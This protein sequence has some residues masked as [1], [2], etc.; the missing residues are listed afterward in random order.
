LS[1][2]GIDNE[3]T[4][5]RLIAA[6]VVIVFVFGFFGVE[7]GLEFDHLLPD[8]PTLSLTIALGIFFGVLIAG[9]PLAVFITEK[10]L[11]GNQPREIES[12]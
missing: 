7:L 9:W 8:L 10:W 5:M 12:K 4:L 2:A 11:M 1:K 6:Y 3:G